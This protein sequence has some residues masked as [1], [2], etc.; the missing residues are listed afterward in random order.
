MAII[1]S[2]ASS[3]ELTIDPTS[4]AARATLRDSAGNE[5]ESISN[6]THYYI[7]AGIIQ[8]VHVSTLNSST[9]QINAG[10]TWSGSK[11]STL[12][13]SG[14]QINSFMDKPHTVVVY[15]S[16]DGDNWDMSDTHQ[17][18]SNYG[19]SRTVQAT[20][21]WYKVT[22]KNTSGANSTVCR[23]Q[24]CLCPVVEALPRSLTSGGNLKVTASAEWQNN[25]LTTGLYALSNFRTVG[26]TNATQNILTIENP[27]AST[28]NIAVRGL[29]VE[30]DSTA[31][32]T[33]VA[34]QMKLSRTTGLPT[35]GTVLVAS[36]FQTSYASPQAIVRGATASDGGGA[37]AITAT[38]GATLWSKF[39][40]RLHT[41]VGWLTHPGYGMLPDVGADLRQIILV[42]GEALLVQSVTAMAATTHVNV[43]IS[44]LEYAAV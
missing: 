30:T 4:K 12:G 37:T 31:V 16:M 3:D 44:W 24:T 33:S 41:A 29:F 14:I 27:A 43:N 19:V 25:R 15:Q 23:I 11:E 5:F 9:A 26:D 17:V 7:G 38:A 10:V 28:I 13:C 20:G 34:P 6:G 40:D 21:S 8:D 42:P 22:V 2:G 18:P 32:L 1:K 35:G 36:K 39:I